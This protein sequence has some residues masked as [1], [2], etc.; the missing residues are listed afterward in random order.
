MNPNQKAAESVAA[1]ILY[2]KSVDEL[3]AIKEH[4]LSLKDKRHSRV[5][6]AAEQLAIDMVN[7]ALATERALQVIRDAIDDSQ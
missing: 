3:E 7:N 6:T 1:L 2:G 4:I 5:L